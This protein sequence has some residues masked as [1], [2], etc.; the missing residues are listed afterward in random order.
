MKQKNK[1]KDYFKN[2]ELEKKQSRMDF[3]LKKIMCYKNITV[4]ISVFSKIIKILAEWNELDW[5]GISLIFMVF[6]FR[7][8]VKR[9]R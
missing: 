4:F 6:Y 3:S 2:D 1:E 7:I 8:V 9:K 5:M